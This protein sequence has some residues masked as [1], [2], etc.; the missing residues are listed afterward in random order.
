MKNKLADV[1]DRL[2]DTGKADQ[3][4][5]RKLEIVLRLGQAKRS[6]KPTGNDSAYE[7]AMPASY[8]ATLD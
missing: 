1:V 5:Q 8:V 7:Q 6:W 2:K 4:L 3:Y